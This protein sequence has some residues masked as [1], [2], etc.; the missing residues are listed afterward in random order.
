MTKLN[1]AV[2]LE[3][4]SVAASEVAYCPALFLAAPASG[5]GKTTITAALSRYF[6]SQ[7]KRVKVFKTGPDYLDPQILAQASGSPVE[8][9][10]MWMAGEDWCRQQLHEAA[11]TADLILVE[12]VMGL[13]DGEPSSA[14]LAATFNIPVA[15]VMDVK[16]MAQTVAAIA[17]GLAHYRDDVQFAG[18]LANNCGSERHAQLIRDALPEDLPL[19]ATLKRDPDIALPERHLGLVQAEE[20]H[21]ELEQR[22]DAG[23]EWIAD[24]GFDLAALNIEPVAFASAPVE[25]VP[26]LLEGMKIGISK[27]AAFSFIYDA[28][29]RLLEAMGA[30]YEFFSPMHDETL[31]EVD[32]LWLVGGYPELHAEQLMANASMRVAMREFHAQ[33]KP[34]LA[35]CGG[36]LYCMEDLTTLEG[37]VC[38]M[39]G[40]MPGHGA[41]RGKRGCQGMQSLPLPEGEIRGHAHHRSRSAET[42]EP[43]AH[44]KRQRHPAPGEA[45]YRVGSL[46]ASYLH[47]YFPSNPVAVAKL[48][49]GEG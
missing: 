12:G 20:I 41:M 26:R 18:L 35:E 29:L 6:L 4:V 47:L 19:L 25:D 43:I 48:F 36:F 33:G 16:G 32:A 24:S 39:A 14:D 1:D 31:P 46:T 3:S 8:Q 13:F 9:L 34:V 10:D 27:D 44:G 2:D 21:G 40:L 5:Q 42:P 11:K 28:N 17:S 15:L 49:R 37:E 38:T 23:A 7:G 30:T 45:I 22:F